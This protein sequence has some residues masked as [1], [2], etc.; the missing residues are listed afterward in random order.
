MKNYEE[1]TK[2]QKNFFSRLEQESAKEIVEMNLMK[3]C[4]IEMLEEFEIEELV[5]AERSVQCAMSLRNTAGGR[6]APDSL[7]TF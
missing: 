2:D 5:V 1:I 6:L 4:W 3:F 7:G